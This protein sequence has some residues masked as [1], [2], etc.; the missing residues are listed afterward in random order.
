VI[1]VIIPA[2]NEEKY[3]P[4]TLAAAGAALEAIAGSEII[5]VDNDS[6]DGTRHI[7]ESFGSRVITEHEHNIAKVRNTGGLAAGGELLVFLDADTIV[8]RGLFEKITAAMSNERCVGGAVAVEYEPTYK[9]KWIRY[10]LMAW[11]F[12]G[13]VFRMRQGAAQFCRRDSFIELGG[14]DTTIYIGEDIEFHWRLARLAKKRGGYT[15]FVEEPKVRTSSR[16]YDQMGIWR[17]LLLTHP[18][19]ILLAWRIPSV[20]KDWYER[21]IR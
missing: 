3:L 19:T 16:R 9:R 8:A 15:A 18:I 11:L 4:A 5:V 13:R 10:Y 2:Y 17:T 6:T 21:A 7:A 14:Y 20:W 12:W 1:S